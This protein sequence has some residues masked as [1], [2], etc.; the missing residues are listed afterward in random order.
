MDKRLTDAAG[1]ELPAR[2]GRY[3]IEGELGRGGMAVVYRAV[4][5][6]PRGFA[7][8]VCLKRI[9]P[10]SADDP[11]MVEM[12]EREA[13]IAATLQHANVVQLFDF[14]LHEGAP[15]LVMELVDGPSLWQVFG[16][17]CA[18]GR[19]LPADV[20]CGI[21][22][23]VLAGLHHVHTRTR[24]GKPLGLVHRDVSLHNILVSRAG[25]VKVA[26][27]G[28]ARATQLGERTRTGVLKGKLAYI[29]PEYAATGRADARAD[30]FSVGVVLHELLSGRRRTPPATE[31]EGLGWV[32]HPELQPLEELRPDLPDALAAAVRSLVARLPGD[33]P[34]D[35]AQAAALLEAAQPPAGA[36]EIA[37]CLERLLPARPAPPA[38]PTRSGSPEGSSGTLPTPSPFDPTLTRRPTGAAATPPGL[39]SE[40]TPDASTAVPEPPAAAPSRRRRALWLA[41]GLAAAVAA[42]LALWLVPGA[43]DGRS[44]PARVAS[45]EAA[46]S[47]ARAV[48]AGPASA[49][50][51]PPVPAARPVP[52]PLPPAAPAAAASPENGGRAA[53]AVPP[54]PAPAPATPTGPASAAASPEN[55]GRAAETVPPGPAPAPATPTGSASAAAPPEDGGR[56]AETV[57]PGPAPA[58]ATPTGPAPAAPGRGG[59]T[60]GS[61]PSP[62]GRGGGGSNSPP[63]AGERGTLEV[64]VLPW[65]YVSIDGSAPEEMPVR[66]REVTAGRHLVVIDNPSLSCRLEERV[67]VPAGEVVVVRQSLLERCGRAPAAP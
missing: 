67:E 63:G 6:G 20:A 57:P 62:A 44:P 66:G 45:G 13:R 55:G 46:P 56:A 30:L 50:V 34:D 36:A 8:Q 11:L 29:A 43:D 37:R 28:I 35:A 22:T 59:R 1:T 24:D 32:L 40:F 47:A 33:R 10:G 64:F 23:Q 16:A 4:L 5:D 31:A 12:F 26:D 42:A 53:E 51:P 21:V 15:F 9:L 61:R 60:E 7:K 19:P 2:I 48:A 25:E 17:A 39:R 3:R 58:P 52:P 65:A 54:G 49:A 38:E 18:A 27:F 41:G 14:D